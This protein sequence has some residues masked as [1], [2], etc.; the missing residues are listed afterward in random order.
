[1]YFIDDTEYSATC[2]H[3]LVARDMLV[4]YR[5]RGLWQRIKVA[6]RIKNYSSLT[7]T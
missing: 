1:M 7:E 4:S 2:Q 6:S 5:G 3:T